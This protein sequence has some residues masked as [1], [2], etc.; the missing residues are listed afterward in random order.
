MDLPPKRDCYDTVSLN[1]RTFSTNPPPP[2]RC[3]PRRVQY[4]RTHDLPAAT[5]ASAA[6]NRAS[7]GT[8]SALAT[9][10]RAAGAAE[11]AAGATLRRSGPRPLARPMRSFSSTV[12]GQMCA[13]T[14]A[15]LGVAQ[16]GHGAF[17][18][19]C[20]EDRCGAF[21]RNNGE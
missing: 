17:F 13:I 1:A 19:V 10:G 5:E 20:V 7:P 2:S 21:A 3:I 8:L 15:G 18:S 9:S 11:R 16:R 4:C 14:G 6:A 12:S